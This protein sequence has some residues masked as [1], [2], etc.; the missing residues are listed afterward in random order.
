MRLNKFRIQGFRNYSDVMY[1]AHPGLNLLVGNNGAGKTNFLDAIYYA[2]LGKSYFSGFDKDV[3]QNGALY[4]RLEYS[5]EGIEDVR[6]VVFKWSKETSKVVEVDGRPI[7]KLSD[8]IGKINVVMMAPQDAFILL[9]GN[10]E[11]RRWL[12]QF[13]SQL[14]SDYAHQ[15]KLY[16]GILKRRNAY[17]KETL[18]HK[19]EDALL[20]TFW[21]RMEGPAKVIHSYRH[22]ILS[23]IGD[24]LKGYYEDL[25]GGVEAVDIKYSS[26]LDSGDWNQI[27]EKYRR[28]EILNRSTHEGIHKDKIDMTID[29]KP[30]KYYGSQGQKKSFF[31]ALKFAEYEWLRQKGGAPIVLIDDI[32]AKLDP[33][34]IERLFEIMKGMEDCQFFI[35]DTDVSRLQSII[36]NLGLP[37]KMN[38]IQNAEISVH[39]D[40]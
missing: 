4:M 7:S 13:L 22:E 19:I 40:A 29:S 12:D 31:L 39:G 23:S 24:A 21:A 10:T 2:S 38:V 32:F 37:G 33:E 6:S 17:L 27:A 35:T 28:H 26:I 25:S 1:E 34:R 5:F 18:E 8:Y 30:I 9:I 11:R 15:L 14:D 16:N 36:D 3:V 20:D